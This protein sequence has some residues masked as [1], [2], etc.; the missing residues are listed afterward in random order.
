MNRIEFSAFEQLLESRLIRLLN[1]NVNISGRRVINTGPSVDKLDYVNQKQLNDMGIKVGFGQDKTVTSNAILTAAAPAARV[2]IDPVN[3]IRVYNASNV[4]VFQVSLAGAI[5]IVDEAYSATTWDAS[6]NPPTKNA[7]RDYLEAA[8]TAYTPTYS[9]SVGNAAASFTA[10]PT[11]NFASYR[12]IGKTVFLRIS[13]N[14]TLLAVTPSYIQFTVPVTSIAGNNT[15]PAIV[16]DSLSA[17]YETGK[18]I[19]QGGSG[20]MRVFK[21][22]GANW[23]SGCVVTGEITHTFQIN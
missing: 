3:G 7:I 4:L 23:T 20:L 14:A 13:Y 21:I 1:E 19:S 6:L 5:L 17:G 12:I 22:N 10:T 11:T 16:Y 2:H 9:S 15:S 18:I 8:W